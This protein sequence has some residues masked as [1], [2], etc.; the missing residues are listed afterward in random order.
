MENAVRYLTKYDQEVGALVSAETQ[1]QRRTLSLIPSENYSSKAVQLALATS[2][3]NKYAEG[4]PYLW[5]NGSREEQQ[6][7]RYYRGQEHTNEL[8]LLAIRRALQLF[9]PNPG[10]YHA[11]VQPLS[12]APA[13]L[14][15]LSAFLKPGDTFLGLALDYGGHLTHGH[16]VNITG[17]YYNAVQYRL[18]ESYELDYEEIRRLAK[19]HSPKL[20]ICGATAYPLQISFRQ[21]GAIARETGAL[22]VA[23]IAH[24]CGLCVTGYHEHPFPHADI[25]TTTTHKILRGPRAGLIVCKKPYGAAIDRAVFPGLQGGPHMN[26]IAAM[27]VAL[28]EAMSPDYKLYAGQVVRNAKL[29]SE[30]LKAEG[31]KL[32]GGRTDN[33]LLLLDVVGSANGL[34]A[35]N[36]NWLAKRWE[37]AGIVANKNAIPGDT[38]PWYP[39]GVRLGTPAI[40]TI[41]MKDQD[42]ANVAE[43]II[44]ATR[45][46]ENEAELQRVRDEIEQFMGRFPSEPFYV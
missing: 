20:I 45:H 3:T 46:A 16:N 15:V 21:L 38:K 4:Y 19:Q 9:T 31:F 1:R 24:I 27:A 18:N 28:K 2:Y 25:V 23:D 32:M 42:M 43:W 26:T 5:S 14:A 7:G 40:T 10:D 17:H 29:L 36:G 30:M 13:N 11:N 44:R 39:S 33:H 6:S 8:E 22:L 37:T 34:S 35:K 12:G 41:G